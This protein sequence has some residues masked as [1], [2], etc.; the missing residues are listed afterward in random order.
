MIYPFFKLLI[1]YAFLF[2]AIGLAYHLMP[3][4]V[5]LGLAIP[6]PVLLMRRRFRESVGYTHV[7]YDEEIM[8]TP[9]TAHFTRQKHRNGSRCFW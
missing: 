9:K 8:I 2:S 1:Q 6:I 4:L 3:A 7:G 5:A